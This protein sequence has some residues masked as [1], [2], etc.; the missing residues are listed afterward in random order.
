MGRYEGDIYFT[1]G[2]FYFS[3]LAAAEFYYRFATAAAC[4]ENIVLSSDNRE[5]LG[6]IWARKV[7][8]SAAR[9]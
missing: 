8:A 9:R 5:I 7:R 4:G 6:E 2:A 3:T 1:G